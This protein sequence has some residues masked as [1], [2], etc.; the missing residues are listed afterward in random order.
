MLHIVKITAMGIVQ[1][2]IYLTTFK[3]QKCIL[4]KFYKKISNFYIWPCIQTQTHLFPERCSYS[5]KK[6]LIL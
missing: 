2:C 6:R 3:C 5:R 4:T 1:T